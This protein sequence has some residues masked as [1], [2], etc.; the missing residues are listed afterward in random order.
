MI[1][2]FL[3]IFAGFAACQA[4]LTVKYADF[5]STSADAGTSSAQSTRDVGAA[6]LA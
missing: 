4:M 2:S 1:A 6:K 3:V 5:L